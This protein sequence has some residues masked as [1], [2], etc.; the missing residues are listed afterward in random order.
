M[1]QAD[2]KV[3]IYSEFKEDH[4]E[5]VSAFSYFVAFR[6]SASVNTVYR[7]WIVV[8]QHIKFCLVCG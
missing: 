5:V 1:S 4:F 6:N 8:D 2:R 3:D 7:V